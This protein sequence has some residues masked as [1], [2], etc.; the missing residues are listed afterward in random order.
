MVC[1][2]HHHNSH[3][4]ASWAFKHLITMAPDSP[5]SHYP[6]SFP[7]RDCVPSRPLYLLLNWKHPMFS[8]LHALAGSVLSIQNAYPTFYLRKH[9]QRSV[10][11][12]FLGSMKLEIHPQRY[13]VRECES[14]D[15]TKDERPI[16]FMRNGYEAAR[17]TW[18]HS[19][20]RTR[21]RVT[22]SIDYFND[23]II[24]NSVSPIC[25]SPIMNAGNQ[26]VSPFWQ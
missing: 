24:S 26:H 21:P 25:S 16:I 23:S 7:I 4:M 10:L 20:S 15:L 8:N 3:S 9:F 11:V 2:P 5:S 18:P 14:S 13:S 17:S 6:H 1:L 19:P 12:L 22:S